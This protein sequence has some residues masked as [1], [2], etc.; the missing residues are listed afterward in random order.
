MVVL[1]LQLR[2]LAVQLPWMQEINEKVQQIID[3]RYNTE[4]FDQ[5][6]KETPGYYYH[7]NKAKSLLQRLEET[8]NEMKANG[9]IE[10]SLNKISKYLD[11]L[12]DLVIF[13]SEYISEE[14]YNYI[15][16]RLSEISNK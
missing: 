6:L 10:P 14:T 15:I 1:L 4:R 5:A 9:L 3:H 13:E 8:T 7:R 11:L 16:D 12:S 2:G